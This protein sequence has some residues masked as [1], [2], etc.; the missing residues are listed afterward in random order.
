VTRKQQVEPNSQLLEV[1][2]P[3]Q[4][5]PRLLLQTYRFCVRLNAELKMDESNIPP[6]LTIVKWTIVRDELNSA[7]AEKRIVA[8][9]GSN[10]SCRHSVLD[11]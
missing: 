6:L 10:I 3:Y 9:K 2:R 8:D 5:L 7:P 1:S 11:L 4:N